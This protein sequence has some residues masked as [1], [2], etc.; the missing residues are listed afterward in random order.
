M[1]KFFDQKEEVI[2]IELTPYGREQYS[3][4][5]FSPK[6]YTFHDT[7]I[8]YDGTF[9]SITETQNQ[10]VNR[11]K[12]VTPRL[13]PITRFT[14]SMGQTVSQKSLNNKNQFNQNTDYAAVYNRVL[15]E[16]SVWSD[17]MP[18]WDITIDRGS[19][20]NF[21]QEV[22]YL[23]G[24]TIPRV[25]S[26]F[27]IEYEYV[28]TDSS[29]LYTL[30]ESNKII[31]DIQELNTQFKLNGNFDIEILRKDDSGELHA[32]GFINPDTQNSEA[33]TNQTFPSQMAE[34]IAGTNEDIL[35]GF[36]SL[37]NS[38]VEY[39]LDVLL[40]QEID[41]VTMPTNSTIYK[42]NLERNPGNICLTDGD[43]PNF[44]TDPGGR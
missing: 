20:T 11:I 21:N 32:L 8:L 36:P 34:T 43:R 5:K 37:D 39:Y 25:S 13:R 7:G 44:N 9:G 31:L 17:F 15:G 42:N 40:D 16:S 30:A 24:R 27:D 18:S 38:Y 26:N 14:S 19:S 23:A 1:V 29:T 3:S 22:E 41:G 6:Y 28:T 2:Q 4:G 12:N 35:A 10:I 33:L